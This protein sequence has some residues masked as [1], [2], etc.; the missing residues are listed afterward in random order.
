MY[1]VGLIALYACLGVGSWLA[2]VCVHESGHYLAGLVGG[3]PASA[4]RIRLLSFDVA[5][6]CGD[7]WVGPRPSEFEAYL[8]TLQRHLPTTPRLYLYTAGGLLLETLFTAVVTLAL[9]HAGWPNVALVVVGVSLW[10][11][12]MYLVVDPVMTWRR[13]H[14]FGDFAGLWALAKLSTALLALVL[15]AVRVGLLWYAAA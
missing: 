5:L 2:L 13:G 8:A 1:A 7:R 3:I 9:V 12:L 14:P 11:L 4:M 6:R 15:L 10:L